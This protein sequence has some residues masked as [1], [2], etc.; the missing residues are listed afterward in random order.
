MA[1]KHND[2]D[3]MCFSIIEEKAPILPVT[4]VEIGKLDG[5]LYLRASQDPNLRTGKQFHRSL[6][7]SLP[8]SEYHRSYDRANELYPT[9]Q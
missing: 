5:I 3:S 4:P 7:R 2:E 1:E 8:K 9:N 6:F